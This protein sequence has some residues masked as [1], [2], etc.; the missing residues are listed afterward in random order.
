VTLPLIGAP[1]DDGMIWAYK[2]PFCPTTADVDPLKLVVVGI[3][4]GVCADADQLKIK[5]T[6]AKPR[7]MKLM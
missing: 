7:H 3:A 5:I 6:A 4:A 1:T 2:A